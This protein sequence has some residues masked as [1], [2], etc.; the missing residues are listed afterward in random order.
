MSESEPTSMYLRKTDAKWCSPVEKFLLASNTPEHLKHARRLRTC[1]LYRR[2][3]SE[4]PKH[5]NLD[6]F[7]FCRACFY[8][9]K[10]REI[11]ERTDKLVGLI[12]HHKLKPLFLTLRI[13]TGPDLAERFAFLEGVYKRISN[14]RKNHKA[15]RVQFNEF[16]RPEFILWFFEIARGTDPEMW[17][18]HLHGI[19]LNRKPKW[20]FDLN[21]LADRWKHDA[22]CEIPPNVRSSIPGHRTS[23]KGNVRRMIRY[24]LKASRKHEDKW[25]SPTDRIHAFETLKRRQLVREMK[26][27]DLS[28]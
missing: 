28:C 10:K 25:L 1:R 24:S 27:S 5:C 18:P 23:T 15:G 21:G 6:R 2:F 19:A 8:R 13:P 3:G 20:K 26:Y 4:T 9:K 11:R 12:Q 16:C 17:F 22:G 7:M 14:S